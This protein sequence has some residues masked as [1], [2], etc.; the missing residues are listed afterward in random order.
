ML[1]LVHKTEISRATPVG[2]P[3][4]GTNMHLGPAKPDSVYYGNMIENPLSLVL[5]GEFSLLPGAGDGVGWVGFRKTQHCLSPNSV[6][7][8]GF[9]IIL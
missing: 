5:L 6:R 3:R 2:A 1:N 4:W 7:D 9:S 8:R